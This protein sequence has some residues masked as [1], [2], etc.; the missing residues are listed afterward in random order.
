M[1]SFIYLSADEQR[2]RLSN[3][4]VAEQSVRGCLRR[5]LI[6]DYLPGQVTYNL[7]EHF[8]LALSRPMMMSASSEYAGRGSSWFSSMRWNDA[9][10]LFGGDKFN[11]TNR[12]GLRRFIDMA[13]RQ[14]LKV[15]LYGSTGSLRSATQTSAASG[16]GALVEAWFRYA[17][18][19]PAAH[20]ASIPAPRLLALMDEWGADGTTTI[21]AT[22][23]RGT[24]IE[25][26]VLASR[27]ARLRRRVRRP[28]RPGLRCR[29]AARRHLLVHISGT[30]APSP[31]CGL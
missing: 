22:A 1:N 12:A 6:T 8:T 17:H 31:T 7:G 25:D 9:E 15:L 2:R 19:S 14:G 10:R 27:N 29:Q 13:H 4:A 21:A 28:A 23:G 16:R 30:G 5:H 24:P 11:L 26:E 18:C 20:P 3:I